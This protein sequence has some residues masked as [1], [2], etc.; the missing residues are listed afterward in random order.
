MP[1]LGVAVRDGRVLV[2]CRAGCTQ[3]VVLSALRARGLWPDAGPVV[4]RSSRSPAEEARRT[5]LAEARRQIARLA[6]YRD[7]LLE[8]DSIRGAHQTAARARAVATTL[9]DCD[10]AWT[11]AALAAALEVEAT[12]AAPPDRR[13]W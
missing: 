5:V 10:E 13:A 9:G 2:Y 12:S 1:S 8:A 6:P 3:A 4:V 11:L 7:A